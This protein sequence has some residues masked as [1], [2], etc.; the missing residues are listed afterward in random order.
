MIWFLVAV[1]L[2]IAF[3]L[4]WIL[5]PYYRAMPQSLTSRNDLN[6]QVYQDQIAKI[7]QDL[8]NGLLA[9]EQAS[10]SVAEIQQRLL[11]DTEKEFVVHEPHSSRFTVIAIC[12]A[13]P[14]T[15]LAIYGV[16]GVPNELMLAP[17]V[18]AAR[19]GDQPPD[20]AKMVAGLAKKLEQEPDNL[21]GWAMLGRS[22]KVMGNTLEAE[23]A[24][25]RA[26][27][28]LMTDAQLLA[29]YADV[30]AA[31]AKG[32]F[33]GKPIRLIERALKVDPQNPMALWLAATAAMQGQDR[34]KALGYLKRLIKVLPPDSEDAKTIQSAIDQV[35]AQSGGK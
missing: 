21:E 29:D 34:P 30:S 8:A 17:P 27:S 31:N 7:D 9:P 4:L 20:I 32:D 10:E 12:L 33:S 3:F 11:D 18:K 25:D 35:S 14:L 15:A 2:L 13:A 23:K 16:I 22:Y 6:V 24:Y 19:T 28:F 1:I 5:Q 26:G